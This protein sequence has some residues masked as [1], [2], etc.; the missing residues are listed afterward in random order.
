MET[1]EGT[2]DPAAALADVAA[3]RAAAARRLATPWWYHPLLGL[4]VAVMV[5]GMSRGASGL[6]SGSGLLGFGLLLVLYRRLTGLWLNLWHVPGMRR[7]AVLATVVTYVVLLVGSLLEHVAGVPWALVV[8]GAVLGAAYV[9]F[10]RWVERRVAEL[11]R[12]GA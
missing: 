6:V 2:Y 3:G 12:Q 7:P 1:H 9:V 11:W 5:G 10:W 4:V 8:T